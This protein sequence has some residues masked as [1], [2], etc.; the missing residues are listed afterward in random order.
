MSRKQVK[1]GHAVILGVALVLAVG[2]HA[3]VTAYRSRYDM[4]LRIS[5]AEAYKDPVAR[6]AG[7]L[8]RIGSG[9]S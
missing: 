4:C 6:C 8:C 1:T 5:E 7:L 2:I 9:R 3:A